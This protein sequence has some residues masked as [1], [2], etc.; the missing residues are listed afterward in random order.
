MKLFRNDAAK[1]A[2][3]NAY[4]E[5]LATWDIPY[6]EQFIETDFGQTYALITGPKDAPPLFL[7]PQTGV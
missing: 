3:M 6:E 5:V 7:L 2:Y 1:E 4:N